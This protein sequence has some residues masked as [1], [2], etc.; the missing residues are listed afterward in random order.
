MRVSCVQTCTNKGPVTVFV[1][2]TCKACD[3]YQININALTFEQYLS[4]VTGYIGVSWQQVALSLPACHLC[5]AFS[6]PYVADD[7]FV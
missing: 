4:T 7:R 2:D 6:L 1:T 3:R 5:L